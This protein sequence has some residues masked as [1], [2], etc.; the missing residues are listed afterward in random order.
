MEKI[1]RKYLIENGFKE[2]PSTKRNIGCLVSKETS[3][4]KNNV[5][6]T[7]ECMIDVYSNGKTIHDCYEISTQI[8]KNG[9]N[10]NISTS[11]TDV[12]TINKFYQI[13]NEYGKENVI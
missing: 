4:T 2:W 12:E 13:L 9:I 6:I 8:S 1:T 7:R 5:T 11:G 3:Y 10:L